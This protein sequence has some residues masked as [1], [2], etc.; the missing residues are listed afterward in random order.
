MSDLNLPSSLSPSSPLP[1]LRTLSEFLSLCSSLLPLFFL[2]FLLMTG[3]SSLVTVVV[4][5]T[6]VVLE[7]SDLAAV[8]SVTVPLPSVSVAL[9]PVAVSLFV[10]V[11]TTGISPFSSL[12][13][14]SPPDEV[15]FRAAALASSRLFF[16]EIEAPAS[17]P[18]SADDVLT[19]GAGSFL[20]LGDF[21]VTR[22]NSPLSSSSCL[23]GGDCFSVTACFVDT[24]GGGGCVCDVGTTGFPPPPP[25]LPL[26]SFPLSPPLPSPSSLPLS[27]PLPE[28]SGLDLFFF[29]G[30]HDDRGLPSPP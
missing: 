21:E 24:G 25:V 8:V 26:L 13:A 11:A 30:L 23:L 19:M 7:T 16:L 5:A 12:L 18:V 27:P 9:E 29:L 28:T 20:P 10:I 22:V 17:L 6:V 2:V 3:A 4:L 14:L 15:F 1:E